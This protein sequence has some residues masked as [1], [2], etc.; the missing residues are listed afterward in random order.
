LVEGGIGAWEIER[1]VS[2]IGMMIDEAE[3]TVK[4]M[5]EATA[6]ATA[7]DTEDMGVDSGK[8]PSRAARTRSRAPNQ[9][10]L[11]TFRRKFRLINGLH[12]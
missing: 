2:G 7:G 12:R 4:D 9:I 10:K 5:A 3:P 1:G 8:Y 11:L 6:E